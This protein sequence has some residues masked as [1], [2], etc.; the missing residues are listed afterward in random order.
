MLFKPMVDVAS[1]PAA[2]GLGEAVRE[3][4]KAPAPVL[5]V[6]EPKPVKV[7]EPAK[8]PAPKVEQSFTFA[9][10]IKLD[11]RGDVKDPEQVVRELEPPLRRLFEAF[12][13]EVAS[14]MSS[15]QL[16]DQPHV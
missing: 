6:P 9:P 15:A 11:V 7:P 16:F 3:L 14:R 2:A 13:R 4:A 10:S 5:P 8:V 12:Q 1:P